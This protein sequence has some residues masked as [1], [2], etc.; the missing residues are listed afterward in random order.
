MKIL[1][2]T[3]KEHASFISSTL[4]E[5]GIPVSDDIHIH[6]AGRI[7][8]DTAPLYDVGVSFMYQYKVPARQ[9]NSYTWINFHPAPLPEYG[10]RNLCYHAIMNGE[11]EF[12]STIHYMD[13]GFDTGRIIRVDRFKILPSDTSQDVSDMALNFSREQF[14]GYFPKILKG[15]KFFTSENVNTKYYEKMPIQDEIWLDAETKKLIRAITYGNF[16]PKVNIGGITYKIVRD[17]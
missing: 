16:H 4:D 12:G 7:D 3:N 14:K 17:E 10:G 6:W 1:I 9:V 13:E 2:A 5:L 11:M 8:F 15:E